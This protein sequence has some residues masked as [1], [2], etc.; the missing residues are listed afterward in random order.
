MG[1]RASPTIETAIVALLFSTLAILSAVE[2]AFLPADPI[3]PLVLRPPLAA[4]PWTLVTA[5]YAHWNLSHLL[6]NGLALLI[7][8]SLVER[9]TS[10]LRF[11]AFFL[12]TGMLAGV[13]E[14]LA[15][16][17][18]N[19][20]VAVAGMSGAVFALLGY[21]LAG[22]VATQAILARIDLSPKVQIALVLV[23]A[24]GL[25]LVTASPGVA[26][27]GHATGLVLGLVAGGLGLLDVDHR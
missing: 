19:N 10:R 23:V 21:L 14:V 5:V 6:A 3:P 13:G 11:H 20:A 17:A 2:S 4:E 22:N 18:V 16:L 26:L 7:V 15:H 25:T 27:I 9:R 12:V 8:G 24:V 1:R